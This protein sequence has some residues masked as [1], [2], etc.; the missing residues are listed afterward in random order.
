MTSTRFRHPRELMAYLGWCRPN[1]RA[2]R[3]SDVAR[4]RKRAIRTCGG[5]SLKPVGVSS[6]P[7]IGRQHAPARSVSKVVCDI[8]WKAQLRLTGRF[9]GSSRAGKQTEVAT[10][11]ARELPGF[12]RAI[13]REG[14]PAG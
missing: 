2:G 11:I 7:R 9:R 4:S 14:A 8:A 3:A 10:A 5:Y 13:A 1:T 12:I 6:V